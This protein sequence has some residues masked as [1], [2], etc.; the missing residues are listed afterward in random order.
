MGYQIEDA[1]YPKN[2]ENVQMFFICA[3]PFRR[4]KMYAKQVHFRFKCEF[5]GL[6]GGWGGGGR[7]AAMMARS[8]SMK[9]GTGW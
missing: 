5:L 1:S 7:G 6:W 9:K 2:L 3:F 4:S 8:L